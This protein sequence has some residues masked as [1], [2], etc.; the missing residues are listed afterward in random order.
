MYEIFSSGA[1]PFEDLQADALLGALEE[2]F[3]QSKLFDVQMKCA[4]LE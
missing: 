1:E 4:C 2:A 3:A